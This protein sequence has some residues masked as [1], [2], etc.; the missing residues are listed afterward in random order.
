[1]GQPT[2]QQEVPPNPTPAQQIEQTPSASTSSQPA[3]AEELDDPALSPRAI[4]KV[5]ESA[6]STIVTPILTPSL[7][8]TGVQC[9]ILA[10]VPTKGVE[11]QCRM[12]GA[13][14]ENDS[15]T[16]RLLWIGCE[17]RACKY[18]VHADCLLGKS[19][20]L[21][22]EFIEMMPFKCHKHR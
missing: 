1:M 4:R 8:E 21:T 16:R 19:K 3:A 10:G 14:W 12:C 2:E 17:S 13:V 22:P 11:K 6:A 20:R 18:W 9:E 15:R 7:K 5:Q